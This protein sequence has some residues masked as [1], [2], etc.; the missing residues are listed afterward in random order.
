MQQVLP[1][2]VRRVVAAHELGELVGA[3]RRQV[4]LHH[5]GRRV[6]EVE[7]ERTDVPVVGSYA[8]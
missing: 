8:R 4:L 6:D 2:P 1:R 3:P 7:V 5:V